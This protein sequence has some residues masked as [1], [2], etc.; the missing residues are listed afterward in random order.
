MVVVVGGGEGG[1]EG[2]KGKGGRGGG[3]KTQR[4]SL[5]SLKHKK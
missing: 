4:P 1:R 3:V 5:M 2:V